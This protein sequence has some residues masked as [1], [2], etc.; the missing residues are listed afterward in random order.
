MINAEMRTYEYYL[1]DEDNSYGQS[2]L[3]ADENDN[4]I[5]QGTVKI[6]IN[7]TTQSIQDNIRYKGATYIGLTMDKNISDKYVVQYNDEQLKVLYVNPKGIFIQV[8]ME[9]I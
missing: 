5:V 3:I 2:T 7:T 4:P 8:F 1:Y 9:N 6:A